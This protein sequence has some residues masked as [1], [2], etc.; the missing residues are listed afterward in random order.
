MENVTPPWIEIG[1]V[2]ANNTLIQSWKTELETV[3]STDPHTI[4]AMS[5]QPGVQSKILDADGTLFGFAVSI[6]PDAIQTLNPPVNVIPMASW[7]ASA[8]FGAMDSGSAVE[9]SE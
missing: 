5:P 7:V 3:M 8:L 6:R 1:W 4:G 9:D 2:S